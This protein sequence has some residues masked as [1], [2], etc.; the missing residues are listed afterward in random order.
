MNF[1]VGRHWEDIN[2]ILDTV[3]LMFH[4]RFL[5]QSGIPQNEA[6][7]EKTGRGSQRRE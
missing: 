5:T 3:K 7:Q 4:K 2:Y 6:E 1:V